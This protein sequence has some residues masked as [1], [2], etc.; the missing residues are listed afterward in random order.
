M[1]KDARLLQ[2]LHLMGANPVFAMFYQEH[3][4]I[5][6]ALI[7]LSSGFILALDSDR[8]ISIHKCCNRYVLPGREW[9]ICLLP[10]KNDFSRLGRPKKV[11]KYQKSSN[12]PKGPKK[13]NNLLW[14]TIFSVCISVNITELFSLCT[15]NLAGINIVLTRTRKSELLKN[16]FYRID[17]PA[18]NGQKWPK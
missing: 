2:I 11:K 7:G 9:K 8:V 16:D 5:F 17:T 15:D 13:Q 14:I 6:Q 10:L 12:G 3:V 4:L 18:K 1:M